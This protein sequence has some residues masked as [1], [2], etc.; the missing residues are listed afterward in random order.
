ML[1]A[2]HMDTEFTSITKGC[3]IYIQICP[4]LWHL[5]EAKA[6]QSGK[7]QDQGFKHVQACL[8]WVHKPNYQAC[9]GTDCDESPT[10]R[11]ELQR[12][13]ILKKA[14]ETNIFKLLETQNEN[15]RKGDT[16]AVVF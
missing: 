10:A 9:Q 12:Q 8:R 13:A 5:E 7:A 15:T 2:S 16:V 1:S 14:P 4:G 3:A 6:K 11:R